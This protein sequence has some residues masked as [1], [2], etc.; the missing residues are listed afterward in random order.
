MTRETDSTQFV[1]IL[2]LLELTLLQNLKVGIHTQYSSVLILV[3]L[4]LTLLLFNIHANAPG[5]ILVLILV[6]L[7]LTLLLIQN[8]LNPSQ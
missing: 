6:L 8:F 4:E 5:P 3:L 1:L 2:V 7:E